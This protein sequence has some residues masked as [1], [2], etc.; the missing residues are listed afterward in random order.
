MSRGL[1]ATIQTYLANQSQIRILLIDIA[2]PSSTI[3]Y[4][5]APFDVDYSGNTYQAQANFLGISNIEENAELVI[6][7]CQ[8][9]ISAIEVANITTYAKSSIINK[10]VIIR[11]AYLDPTNNSI[12]GTPIVSFKGKITGYTVSDADVTATIA[13]EVSSVFANFDKTNGRY[14]NEGSFQREHP[15][16]RGMEF[17]HEGLADI[18]WGRT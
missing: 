3:Y 1:S 4:T 11:S 15:Q 8:L 10:T 5:T 13:L 7:S 9:V 2:T 16:D 12:V 14:T 17:A 18:K 6:T